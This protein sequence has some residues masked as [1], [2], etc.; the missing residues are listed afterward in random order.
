METLQLRRTIVKKCN[1]RKQILL[2]PRKITVS[3]RRN[4]IVQRTEIQ[5]ADIHYALPV[6]YIIKKIEIDSI[7]FLLSKLVLSTVRSLFNVLLLK[8]FV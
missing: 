8:Q 3:K 2:L 7:Y 5:K 1:K 4:F 6:I